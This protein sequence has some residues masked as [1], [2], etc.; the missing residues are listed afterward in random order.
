MRISLIAALPSI[1]VLAIII[2]SP[3]I[4]LA[5]LLTRKAGLRSKPE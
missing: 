1:L 5:W 2:Y 4:L 3:G